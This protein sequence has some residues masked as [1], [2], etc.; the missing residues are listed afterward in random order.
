MQTVNDLDGRVAIVTGGSAGVGFGIA[1]MLAAQRA[2]VVIA[3]R[4]KDRVQRSV[5]TL[6]QNYG[7]D[8]AIGVSADVTSIADIKGI[9]E[10]A[11]RTWGKIDILVNNAG[12]PAHV[13]FFESDDEAWQSDIE[14]KLLAAVRLSRLVIPHMR[15]QGGGRIVNI[16]SGGAKVQPAGSA[17]TSVTRAA[18]LALTKVLSKEFA[19]DR[20]LVNAVLISTV[21][22]EQWERRWVKEGRQGTIDEFY[23]HLSR[24]I[25]L[26]RFAEP[27]EIGEIVAFIVSDRGS[28]MT[29]SSICM[30]A[31]ASP[32]I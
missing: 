23:A 31:G 18:G 3:A 1:T 9:V 15:R 32:M 29:G 17:P 24:N 8:A 19:A 28:Y 30:D 21:K 26:G 6:R 22:S 12:A 27:V 11:M 10:T 2:H 4:Q 16:L 20:I 13:P 7:E 25:P 5:A 14:L